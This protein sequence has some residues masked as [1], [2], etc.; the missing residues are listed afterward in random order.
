MDW[1]DDIRDTY[2]IKQEALGVYLGLSKSS[3]SRAEGSMQDMNTKAMLLLGPLLHHIPVA[4]DE[5]TLKRLQQQHDADLALVQKQQARRL[6]TTKRSLQT[7]QKQLAQ[8]QHRCTQAINALQLAQRLLQLPEGTEN[9]MERRLAFTG[10]LRANAFKT[11]LDNDFAAQAIIQHRIK[12]CE[13]VLEGVG[14]Q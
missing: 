11:L 10:S 7:A 6:A 14:Q 13:A 1:L 3:I 4:L 12:L 2:G 9:E 5:A 8:M